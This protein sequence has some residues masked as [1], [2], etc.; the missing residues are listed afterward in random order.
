MNGN[1]KKVAITHFK[2]SVICNIENY[3]NEKEFELFKDS[4]LNAVYV[5]RAKNVIFDFV[6]VKSLDSYEYNKL[7]EIV[8]AAKVIGARVIWCSLKPAVVASIVNRDGANFQF[9]TVHGLDEAIDLL[10][11]R[12]G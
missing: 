8:L 12:K 11:A 5:K 4:L 3:L 6:L 7:K 2:G 9:E 10:S 1:A